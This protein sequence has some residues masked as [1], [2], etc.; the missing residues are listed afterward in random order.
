MSR[1]LY[2]VSISEP[3]WNSFEFSLVSQRVRSNFYWLTTSMANFKL[4]KK[5]KQND[6][7]GIKGH[8]LVLQWFNL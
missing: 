6:R 7:D 2:H 4:K 8:S 3:F 5:K 1:K